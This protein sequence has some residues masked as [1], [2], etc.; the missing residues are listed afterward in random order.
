MN[1]QR[2]ALER[3]LLIVSET[4]RLVER[5]FIH[6]EDA[7]IKPDE[8][9]PF[10]ETFFAKAAEAETRSDFRKVMWE[11]FGRLRNAHSWYFDKLAPE[12]AHGI[13]GFAMLKIGD[14]W[15]VHRDITD[16]LTSGDA[17][18]SIEGKHPSEWCKELEPY[19]GIANENSQRIRMNYF[20][21]H[22]I[23]GE[24]FEVEIEDRHGS[25]R[26]VILPKLA[27]D[28]ERILALNQSSETEGKW[29]REGQ[30]A[31]VRIPGFGDP[32]YENRALELVQEYREA[33][34]LIIDVRGNGGGST[35]SRLTRLL[36]DRPY[37]WWAE[38]SR[39]PE[40]MRNR[41]GDVDIR[42]ADDYRYA[43]YRPDW[44]EHANEDERYNGRI[45][46]LADRFTGS[47]AEDFMMPFKDNGR[48]TIVGE[49]TWGST[50]QPAFR[51]FGDDIQVGIG[52]I[53]AYMPNGEPFEGTGIAPDVEVKLIR[54][55][56]YNKRDVALDKALELIDSD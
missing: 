44:Q 52:S 47:A 22:F 29:L 38:R 20:L 24:T 5:A 46:I 18:M 13:V 45:V 25:R 40:W 12:P 8:L 9:D 50:G 2:I 28:D 11:L 27:Q 15:V 26:K 54:E 41:H 30:V 33:S 53:R 14:E 55:H 21:S 36:M 42:F 51:H 1:E 17:V 37:R 6:W 10:A 34:A 43:E 39:H 56:V 31:Y 35:P 7:T 23:P 49:R 16:M 19:I 4:I 3:R 48:A 32:T